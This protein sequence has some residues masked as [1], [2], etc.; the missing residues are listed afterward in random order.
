MFD[1]AYTEKWVKSAEEHFKNHEPTINDYG[2]IITIDWRN[3]NGSNE[4]YVRYIFDNDVLVISGDLG[5]AVIRQWD[6]K[7]DIEKCSC[8]IN[9]MRYITEKCEAY[10]R[11]DLFMWDYEY[12]YE[13]LENCL[14]EKC[15]DETEED[16]AAELHEELISTF[17]PTEGIFFSNRTH[18]LISEMD[19]DIDIY[20]EIEVCGKQFSPRYTA[21]LVGLKM[22]KEKMENVE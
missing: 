5:Y 14:Y 17:S 9:Q 8:W 7:L 10:G 16:I 12:A 15:S 3:K 4:Y 1:K 21:W 22:I 18:K 19:R 11:G 6:N 2:E 13:D 20:T